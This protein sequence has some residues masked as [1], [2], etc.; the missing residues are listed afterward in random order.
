MGFGD[1]TFWQNFW[2]GFWANLAANFIVG[3]LLAGFISWLL[4]KRQ[5]VAAMVDAVILTRS[6]AVVKLQLAIVNSGNVAFGGNEVFCHIY[7]GPGLQVL[8][9][10]FGGTATDPEITKESLP[11]GRSST[12]YRMM[13]TAP[14]FPDVPTGFMTLDVAPPLKRPLDVYYWLSTAVGLFPRGFKTS[15]EGEQWLRKV[16]RVQLTE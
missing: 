10:A 16:G 7:V 9:N 8:H 4:Q 6:E 3:I 2:P 13:L 14:V 1:P 12:H 5:R 11:D 15:L